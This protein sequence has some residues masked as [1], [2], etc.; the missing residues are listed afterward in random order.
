[1]SLG[2]GDRTNEATGQAAIRGRYAEENPIGKL[3][4]DL[5]RWSVWGAFGKPDRDGEENRRGRQG[6]RFSWRAHELE[7]PLPGVKVGPG[8]AL[9]DAELLD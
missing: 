4:L 5:R 9:L 8:D 3:S 1:V 6:A 2:A 7:L